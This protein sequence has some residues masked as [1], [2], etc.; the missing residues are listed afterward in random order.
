MSSH[1]DMVWKEKVTDWHLI[2]RP[3]PAPIPSV[4]HMKYWNTD[5]MFLLRIRR[6]I[7]LLISLLVVSINQVCHREQNEEN[8]ADAR[9]DWRNLH[10]KRLKTFQTS[11]TWVSAGR[12]SF[13]VYCMLLLTRH[14][15]CEEVQPCAVW[16]TN[17][18]TEQPKNVNVEEQNRF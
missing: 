9:P 11:Q 8:L 4:T 14:F 3:L 5:L 15:M 6:F 1:L 10:K 2:K 17:N 18:A 7:S 12:R 13:N 16:S